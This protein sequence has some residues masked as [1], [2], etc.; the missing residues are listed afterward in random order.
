MKNAGQISLESSP[1]RGASRA[2]ASLCCC[3]RCCCRSAA[4]PH[5][6]NGKPTSMKLTLTPVLAALSLA[7]A[8]ETPTA[9]SVVTFNDTFSDF[10]VLQ[11]SG[12]N[13][14]KSAVYGL[15]PPAAALTITV[16][17]TSEADATYTV[18]ATATAQGHW[19]AFLKPTPAGGSVTLTAH[20]AACEN[21]TDAVIKEVTFGDVWYCAGE[22]ANPDQSQRVR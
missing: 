3:C 5:S 21:K 7:A 22:S 19:K 12:T 2:A 9:D 1:G 18:P 10:A 6:T 16:A 8:E 14:T 20:C 4:R 13:N 11:A 17:S 15:A